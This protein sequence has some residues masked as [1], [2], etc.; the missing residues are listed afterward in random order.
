VTSTTYPAYHRLR[1]FPGLE[2]DRQ[3]RLSHVHQGTIHCQV[4][5]K[6]RGE[7]PDGFDTK[8]E[9]YYK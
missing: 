4:I 6:R 7:A 3:A 1:H 8:P 9:L 2:P 5:E